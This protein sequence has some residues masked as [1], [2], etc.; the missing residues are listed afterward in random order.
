MSVTRSAFTLV[1]MT[2]PAHSSSA[3]IANPVVFWVCVGPTTMTDCRGSAARYR[4]PA[5]R[6]AAP[7]AAADRPRVTRPGELALTVSWLSSR[8]R[9]QAVDRDS[10][11]DDAASPLNHRAATTTIQQ[12][13]AAT[14]RTAA[15]TP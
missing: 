13:P 8:R 9:A 4:R 10:A 3:G 1:A 15:S 12:T 2:G 14:T 5:A 7:K 11:R 6:A